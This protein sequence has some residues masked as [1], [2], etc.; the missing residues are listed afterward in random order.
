MRELKGKVVK[1][2]RFMKLHLKYD[3]DKPLAQQ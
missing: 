1:M 3:P 2:E